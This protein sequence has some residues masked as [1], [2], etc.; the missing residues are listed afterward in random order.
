VEVFQRN[1]FFTGSWDGKLTDCDAVINL[2][3]ESLQGFWTKRRKERIY[4]SRILTTRKLVERINN[5]GS[6]VKV[7]ISVSGVGI[8]DHLNWHD[9]S[10]ISFED[11]F[12]G[13]VIVD[14]EGELKGLQRNNI[15]VVI[16]RLGMV[17]GVDGG[18]YPLMSR[19]FNIGLGFTVNC[20]E[21]LPFVHIDDVLRVFLMALGHNELSGVINVVSP[22]SI[23]INN[24]FKTMAKVYHS[25]I[26]VKIPPW[27]LKT[28]L[29]E[30]SILLVRGQRVIPGK[31]A[32][33]GFVF[34]F[35]ALRI[36]MEDLYEK[37]KKID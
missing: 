7:F 19:Y 13:S 8:Y 36:T 4:N 12:L 1:D 18:V 37:N 9:E 10:S 23:S 22:E 14:W 24:F 30:S 21:G 29:G 27:L 35:N 5:C 6:K 31:L 20:S 2:A 32:D 33:Y 34:D 3:G 11:D 28:I 15:R 25:R 16:L 17:L 26:W